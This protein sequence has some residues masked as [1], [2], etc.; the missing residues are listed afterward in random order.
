MKQR[1]G[2]ILGIAIDLADP[3][4]GRCPEGPEPLPGRDPTRDRL[5]RLTLSN[6]SRDALRHLVGH[7]LARDFLRALAGDEPAD[8]A[9]SE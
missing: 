1:G 3:H 5:T 9:A 8:T 4:G 7:Q 2:Y 6:V